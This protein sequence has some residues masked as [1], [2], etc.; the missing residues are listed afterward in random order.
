MSQNAEVA[1]APPERYPKRRR[2][3]HWIGGPLLLGAF[4]AGFVAHETDPTSSGH[5][6]ALRL[7]VLMGLSGA[8]LTVFRIY[9]CLKMPGPAPL[10]LPAW[11]QKVFEWDHRLIAALWTCL[12]HS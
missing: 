12:V 4:V 7:H 6:L 8:L 10:D 11:R 2:V 5:L 9:S 3:L 1:A